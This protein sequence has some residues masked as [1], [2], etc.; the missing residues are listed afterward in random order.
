MPVTDSLLC[1]S[2]GND[3]PKEIKFTT[4]LCWLLNMWFQD[5]ENPM[6]PKVYKWIRIQR[7]LGLQK[8]LSDIVEIT[9]KMETKGE[10]SR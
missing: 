8:N 10:V 9:I 3:I 6:W 1:R 4:N 5:S 2:C 7:E